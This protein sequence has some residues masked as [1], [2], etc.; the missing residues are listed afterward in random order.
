MLYRVEIGSW[1]RL[2]EADA[3]DLARNIAINLYMER[4]GGVQVREAN[5]MEV[6]WVEAIRRYRK[7]D[8]PYYA[9][10]QRREPKP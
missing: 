2:I 1:S 5:D 9:G 6:S 7:H 3:P 10:P 4:Q 8:D